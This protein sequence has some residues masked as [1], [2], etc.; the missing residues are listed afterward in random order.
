MLKQKTSNPFVLYN[1]GGNSALISAASYG[2]ASIVKILLAQGAKVNTV[3]IFGDT[4]LMTAASNG[5][6]EIVNVLIQ[7]GAKINAKT[8]YE[9]VLLKKWKYGTYGCFNVWSY[10]DCSN[11]D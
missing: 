2:H 4:A 3:N 8:M 1:R 7:H 9:Y 11:I 5:Y 10:I 6:S